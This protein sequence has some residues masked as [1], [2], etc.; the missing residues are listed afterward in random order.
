MVGSCCPGWQGT[1]VNGGA[2]GGGYLPQRAQ[3]TRSFFVWGPVCRKPLRSW[4]SWRLKRP[5]PGGWYTAQAMTT[6]SDR[7]SRLEGI[8]EQI[9][10]MLTALQ[11]GQ[12][13]LRTEMREGDAALR[14]QMREGD[15]ALRAEMHHQITHGPIG[16]W[17]HLGNRHCRNSRG[18]RGSHPAGLTAST[19][20]TAPR[21]RHPRRPQPPS[22]S[23][24]GESRAPSPSHSRGGN[25][26]PWSSFDLA[27]DAGRGP[28]SP[29]RVSATSTVFTH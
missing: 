24:Q 5:S 22:F 12:E 9:A 8:V 19:A 17:W 13:A 7:I 6:D 4:R 26:E 23:P 25:P 20:L 14:A 1:G 21:L 16:Q 2:G 15:S 27:W 11:Q 28:A 29:R 3:R 18:S 10:A